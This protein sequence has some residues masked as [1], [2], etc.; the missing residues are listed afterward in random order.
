MPRYI[1]SPSSTS[2]HPV[3]APLLS[4]LASRSPHFRSRPHIL[5]SLMTKG[6][7]Y[8]SHFIDLHLLL[9]YRVAF[10]LEKSF[11]PPCHPPSAPPLKGR[12][13]RC[14]CD[15]FSFVWRAVSPRAEPLSYRELLALMHHSWGERC[16][17]SRARSL[18]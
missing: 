10:F 5:P 15:M 2:S 4:L 3:L 14:G 11:R 1:H 17:R 16:W 6:L 13:L 7:V 9:Q 8:P 18:E 12:F